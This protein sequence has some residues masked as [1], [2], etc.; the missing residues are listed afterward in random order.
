M[1]LKKKDNWIGHILRRNCLLK[2]VIGGKIEGR[3]ELMERRGRGRKQL[4]CGPKKKDNWIGNILRR[5]CLLKHV[6]GGKIEGRTELMERRGRGCKQLLCGP[7]KKR[8]WKVKQ[9]AL[10]RSLWRSF[11]RGGY[12]PVVRHRR[13]KVRMCNIWTSLLNSLVRS[14]RRHVFMQQFFNYPLLTF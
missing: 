9:V 7:K 1:A 5:N 2:H 3:T 11:F 10:V 13:M 6:I 14:V 4:L 12:G 8:Y